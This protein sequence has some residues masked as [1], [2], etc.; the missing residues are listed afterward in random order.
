MGLSR[1]W[2]F[3]GQAVDAGFTPFILGGI[4]KAALAA[5]LLPAAW[6]LVGRR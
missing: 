4:V 5:A 1:A 3:S 2:A 6:K